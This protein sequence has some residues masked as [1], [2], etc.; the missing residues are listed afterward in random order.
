M[1]APRLMGWGLAAIW[2]VAA[3]AAA[4]VM[5]APLVYVAAMTV[6]GGVVG[7]STGYFL[8]LA[9]TLRTGGLVGHVLLVPPATKLAYWGASASAALV[10]SFALPSFGAAFAVISI[11][12]L[13]AGSA[14]GMALEALLRIV[15]RR[16]FP[17]LTL[18]TGWWRP[19]W[20]TVRIAT[21]VAVLLGVIAY[22]DRR[23]GLPLPEAT[24]PAASNWLGREK[25]LFREVLAGHQYDV[26]VLPV[27][28]E[29]PSFDRI[30]RSLMTRYLSQRIEERTG[31]RL[32][33]PT[34]LARA[35][36]A[37][38]RQL[39]LKD[40]LALSEALGARTVVAPRVQ[41]AGQM[42]RVR[43]AT[44]SH[45]GEG[46]W[47]EAAPAVLENLAFS[48][49]LPPSVT[50]RDALDPLLDAMQLGAARAAPAR[51]TTKAEPAPPIDDL[52]RLATH[53]SA[54]AAGRALQLQVLA[55]LH[56]RESLE[57]ETLW[58][59]SLLALWRV[60]E[61]AE[62]SRV[63]EARA[64][65]HLA[66]RPYALERLGKPESPAGRALL[67][68]LNGDVPAAEAATSAIENRALRLA[69]EIELAD[70]YD[71][72][73]LHKRLRARRAVLLK[74][75][76]TDAAALGFR[77]SAADWFTSEVHR[78]VAVALAPVAAVTVDRR[79]VAAMWLR[80]AY[81]R[82]DPLGP[83]DLR[84]ARSIERRHAPVW[85]AKAADWPV[86]RAADRLAE[87]DY[88]DLQFAMNR[89][90]LLKT[91]YSTL[92]KQALPEQAEAI[93]DALGS[94]YQGYPRLMYFHAWALDRIGRQ[95]LPGTQQRLY[96]KSS[97][98]AVSAYGWEGGESH[99][100][101]AVEY[102][103]FERRY[104]KYLDEPPRWYRATVPTER[105][106]FERV[107]YGAREI[108]REI[109]AT[110][111]R[112]QY[113]DRHAQPLRDLV[114]W[115]RRAGRTEEALALVEE[116]RNRFVGTV[117]RAELQAESSEIAG[118]SADLLPAF[119][120]LLELDPDS[121]DARS[122]LAKAY[123]ES[124]KVAQ[125][126]ETW[127]AFP[128]F[129]SHEG[130]NVV[131]LSNRAFEAGNYLY[132]R[133]EARNAVPLFALSTSLRTGSAR[134]IHSRELLAVMENDM[135]SALKWARYQVDRYNDSNAAMRQ[136]LYLFLLGQGE[137][138][139]GQF[140][141]YA[142]RFGTEEVWTA[143]FVAHR[144][145]G[146]EGRALENWL[147]QAAQRDTQRDYLT[148][149]LRERHAFM[150][151]LIDR[152]PSDEALQLVRRVVQA[153]NRSPFYPQ[154]AEG[155]AAFRKGDFAGA[156]QK[157][158][159]VHDD[160]FNIGVNRSQSMSEW[161]PHVVLAYARSGKPK[162]A[163]KLL[164]D[165]FNN[166]GV[167][168]DYLVAS[169]LLEGTAGKHAAAVAALRLAFHRLPRQATRSLPP[170]YTLLEACEL[171]L[172][173][174]K[175]DV[176]RELIEDLARRLQVDLPHAW[177]AAFE[178][179]YARDPG[180]RQLAL[181]AASI[182]DPRSERLA[183]FP[184]AERLTVQRA[185]AR[186]DSLLGA[187]LRATQR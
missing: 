136:M 185:A 86:R 11:A 42:F 52:L 77:L 50:F 82:P 39:D 154:A 115:L 13:C 176:Y 155:Y 170:G 120:E 60:E 88:Y 114:R 95:A 69:A 102:Y 75:P 70:L 58:E 173:E 94:F 90:A 2:A 33:D 44:W 103:N 101:A 30:E 153:N 139:W 166:L 106:R 161:L 72:Y 121:W 55:A 99:L 26:V 105:L 149:A 96:S 175:N 109:A 144:M 23:V 128:G 148:G 14:L 74:A 147:A 142:N 80:W 16:Y 35:L 123:F 122:R 24:P 174:T 12:V 85:K 107:S 127:L 63:L 18:P 41:R 83:N 156:A 78:E 132:Q 163:D 47:R 171:L 159:G 113:S 130:Q 22:A 138:A 164:A 126:Q 3:L 48:D 183:Q 167:D 124:G 7:L 68:A 160:L 9:G 89:R 143:A 93:I 71:A 53:E 112:L 179:K 168:A 177:A 180:A 1:T 66:R 81:W 100:S 38:E 150:L 165:Q 20:R 17:R 104:R 110:R 36:G 151:A 10:P 32:P 187:A 146:L 116:S 40:A 84:L 19:R 21:L 172:K 87:W 76:W 135:D 54:T 145:Q 158:R 46:G 108:E 118:R 133:G 4:Y 61:G 27:Q 182:L 37:R 152:A 111:R 45:A 134:E 28:V 57:A 97:A 49:R 15:L 162:E 131:G 117:A 92:Y 79:E 140:P 137:R 51:T 119:R 181:A 141:D 64:Y 169:A 91:V 29:E 59:R 186:H 157:L 34:L 43:A 65:L 6:A 184:E 129:A 125:A 5:Q 31:S 67:A 25:S 98:L 56:E 178:A 73:N 8:D 62:L